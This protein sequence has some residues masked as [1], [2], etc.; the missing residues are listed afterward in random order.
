MKLKGKHIINYV[1]EGEKKEIV[2]EVELKQHEGMI[3][4]FQNVWYGVANLN[5]KNY[6]DPILMY[7]VN[8]Y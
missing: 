4:P 5:E 2:V 7:C 8:L 6:E 3:K 1:L